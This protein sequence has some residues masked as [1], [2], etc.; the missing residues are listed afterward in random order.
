MRE[1]M[2]AGVPLGAY[3]PYQA[4]HLVLGLLEPAPVKSTICCILPGSFPRRNSPLVDE[5]S[6]DILAN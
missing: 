1:T 6:F 5:S 2:G 4:V 3:M